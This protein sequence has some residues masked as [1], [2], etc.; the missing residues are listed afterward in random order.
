MIH[1][2]PQRPKRRIILPTLISS[3]VWMTPFVV[4]AF[5]VTYPEVVLLF[6]TFGYM[7]VY[8]AIANYALNR[9][10]CCVRACPRYSFLAWVFQSICYDHVCNGLSCLNF[11]IEPNSVCP[12]HLCKR[13]NCQVSVTTPGK[14]YCYRHACI[15]TSCRK[16]KTP[17][18]QTCLQHKC[19][20]CNSPGLHSVNE[21]LL[22]NDHMPCSTEGCSNN[23]APE[24]DVCQLCDDLE[25]RAEPPPT[26]A[27]AT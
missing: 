24:L 25:A 20:W 9:H 16:R 5:L 11:V 17:G 15:R 14:V 7:G 19:H 18:L 1:L 3:T 21:V 26:Y 8:V 13:Q 27:K 4:V 10:T 2:D 22:C 12:N 6:A 23:R